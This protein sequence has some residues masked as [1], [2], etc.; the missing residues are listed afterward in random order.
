MNGDIFTLQLVEWADHEAA[1]RSIREAVFMREQGVPAE[2]E[3]DGLDARCR[4]VLV[5]NVAGA[6]IGCARITENAHIG[7]MAVM[8]DWRGMGVGSAL[9]SA[10]VAHA[11]EKR[12]PEAVLYAQVQAVPF[13]RRFGFAGEGEVFMDAGM[14]HIKM[15]LPLRSHR[16]G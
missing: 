8:R 1:L 14:P 15:R 16:G 4:H 5:Q 3:W 12:H 9:L 13:Y 7:R 2:L 6:A 11:R 10:L